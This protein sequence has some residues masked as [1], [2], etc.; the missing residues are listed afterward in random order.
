MLKL[1]TLEVRVIASRIL[2]MISYARKP[3]PGYKAEPRLI[4]FEDKGNDH[5]YAQKNSLNYNED[6][7][8][9]I[10]AHVRIKICLMYYTIILTLR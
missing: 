5:A 3:G 8:I 6:V 7:R 10:V 2:L 4:C 9:K 1:V